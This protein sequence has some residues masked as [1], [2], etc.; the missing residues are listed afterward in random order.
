MS[1]DGRSA[2]TL[3]ASR[4]LAAQRSLDSLQAS[5]AVRIQLQRRLIAICDAMKKDGTDTARC[6]RRLEMFLAELRRA[7]S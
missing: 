3:L 4:L 2:D 5:A 1:P 7:G 6:V